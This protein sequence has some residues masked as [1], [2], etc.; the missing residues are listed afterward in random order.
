MVGGHVS[1]YLLEK[2][3][4]CS[5]ILNERNYHVFYQILAGAPKEMR[6]ALGLSH[7]LDYE[8]AKPEKNKK[9]YYNY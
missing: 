7:T 1:H 8:V 4:V 5:Q 9:H 6:N 2:T 3:R